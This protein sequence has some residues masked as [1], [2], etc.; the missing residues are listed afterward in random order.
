MRSRAAS[1]FRRNQ[2]A[3]IRATASDGLQTTTYRSIRDISA[4]A[5]DALCGAH[6]VIRGHAYLSAMEA[7]TAESCE[8]FYIVVRDPVSGEHVAQTCL[9]IVTTDLAQLLPNF[10]RA[11]TLRI[12]KLRPRLLYIKLT[13]CGAPL[14]AGHALSWRTDSELQKLLPVF[15]THAEH[16]A[17]TQGSPI[18]VFRDFDGADRP[19]FDGLKGA[20]YQLLPSIPE[21]R[22]C[23]RWPS[24]D[25]YLAHLR[26]RYRKDIKRRLQRA[27][28]AGQR[29]RLI[30]HCGDGAHR[31]ARQV[32]HVQ[33][34]T[35]GFKRE[36]LTS[37]Y[38]DAVNEHLPE[39]SLLLVVEKDR[40]AV[41][42]GM[43]V[44]DTSHAIATFFGREPGA[45]NVEWFQLIDELIRIA[46]ARN[47]ERIDLGRGSYDAKRSVGADIVPLF[48]YVKWRNPVLN[49]LLAWWATISH[50]PPLTPKKAL[51]GK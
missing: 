17:T 41:A 14:V 42:H 24:Y 34:T 39:H 16:I 47:C 4:P 36:I 45:P 28:S 13:E 29:T 20:A 11:L 32:R 43:V 37:A 27:S 40:R 35:Q 21:A 25:A 31:W 48:T 7:A 8:Y 30:Q 19:L 1:W 51:P 26:S 22:I 2:Q 10:L 44:F 38:Y 18:I 5:W 9:Y 12:R 3:T 49:R 15:A 33:S 46:I 23:V 50:H 6:A